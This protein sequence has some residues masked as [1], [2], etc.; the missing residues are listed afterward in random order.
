MYWTMSICKLPSLLKA[1]TIYNSLVCVHSGLS[2]GERPGGAED[3][4]SFSGCSTLSGL[5]ALGTIGGGKAEWRSDLHEALKCFSGSQAKTTDVSRDLGPN[6]PCVALYEARVTPLKTNASKDTKT[7]RAVSPVAFQCNTTTR[8]HHG[9]APHAMW[10]LKRMSVRVKSIKKGS[11]NLKKTTFKKK[12]KTKDNVCQTAYP[13]PHFTSGL[14]PPAATCMN[15]HGTEPNCGEKKL[16]FMDVN[17]MCFR[18]EN[19]KWLF[20]LTLTRLTP[21]ALYLTFSLFPH[22]G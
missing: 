3:R 11:S 21:P 4:L 18:E 8:L 10:V 15:A 20:F 17:D 12:T 22:S 13:T 19:A 9:P 7:P 2:G 14:V 16:V 5:P 1:T 6:S